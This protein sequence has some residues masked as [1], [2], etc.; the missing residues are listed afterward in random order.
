MGG[1]ATPGRLLRNRTF[2]IYI[3]VR[4]DPSWPLG[5]LL[6]QPRDRVHRVIPEP[7]S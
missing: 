7:A 2:L 5:V 6:E 1:L 4:L 3:L